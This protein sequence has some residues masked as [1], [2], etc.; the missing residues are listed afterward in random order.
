M[1]TFN[2]NPMTQ[3]G[4]AG[5]GRGDDPHGA[6]TPQQY[7]QY[8]IK[9]G[10]GDY[11]HV[12]Q[13]SLSDEHSDVSRY[14][15]TGALQYSTKNA[16]FKHDPSSQQMGWSGGTDHGGMGGRGTLESF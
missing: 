13:G 1:T 12:T 6:T 11:L 10:G 14:S 5:A 15:S 16:R 9:G 3:R 7:K 2:G 8:P 4:G